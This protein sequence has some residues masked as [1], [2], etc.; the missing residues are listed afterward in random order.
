M[1]S[2]NFDSLI[3]LSSLRS[4]VG[5]L[6][7]TEQT[8][9]VTLARDLDLIT[10]ERVHCLEFTDG[11]VDRRHM[12]GPLG[13]RIGRTPP[14]D[15]IL[16]DSEISRAHCLVALKD[17]ELYVSDLNSTNGTFVDGIKVDGVTPL[18]VGSILQVGN[19]SLKHEWRTRVEILQ[20]EDFDRELERASSYVQALLPPPLREGPIRSDW[21]YQPSARLGGDAFG[22][23]QLTEDLFFAY[24]IDVAGHGAGAAMHSAAVMNQLRQRSLPDTDMAVPAQVLS[25][26]NK[27]FQMEEHAGLYFTI[28]YGVYNARTRQLDYASGGQHPAYVVPASRS[29]AIPVAT[30]NVVIGALPGM[31]YKQASVQVPAGA[32]LYLF[33]DGVFE[34]VATDG[35][36]WSIDNFLQLI[37]HPPVDGLGESQRLYQSVRRAQPKP[38]DDDFSLLV[39]TFD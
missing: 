28:W 1:S 35:T 39:L 6:L 13:L 10:G 22:Y 12:V 36:Q 11:S 4:E 8:Q 15:V 37:L 27:L 31:G 5:D 19:R 16:A 34:I 14:A 9:V 38:L 7:E 25:T 17:G 2:S 24:L 20:S 26:L 29:Q 18:P 3:C 23:G 32:S 21:I 33:S 30:R